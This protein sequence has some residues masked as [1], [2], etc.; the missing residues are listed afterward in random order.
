MF[1]GIRV[2]IIGIVVVALGGFF[3]FGWGFPGIVS[4][5]IRETQDA[6]T[7]AIP[8]GF[9]LE[10]AENELDKAADDLVSQTRQIA[11]LTVGCTELQEEI[12]KLKD[13]EATETRRVTYLSDAY[14]ATGLASTIGF[15]AGGALVAAGAAL[16]LFSPGRRPATAA[17]VRPYATFG[18]AGVTGRF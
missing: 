15:A 5:A 17:G 2:I 9:Q 18:G 10:R 11:E 4:T 6:A 3:L 13:R 12:A 8:L 14:E 1:S 7:D 16:W